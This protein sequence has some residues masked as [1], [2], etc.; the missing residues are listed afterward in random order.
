[1]IARPKVFVLDDEK[2]GAAFRAWFEGQK[3]T[4]EGAW[5]PGEVK[6]A[7]R[8]FRDLDK[9]SQEQGVLP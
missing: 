3:F 4:Y 5:E 9:F 2:L 8:I 6:V 1:M 7:R